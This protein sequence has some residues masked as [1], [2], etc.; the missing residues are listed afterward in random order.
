VARFS[1]P[2]MLTLLKI[3]V[4]LARY[5]YIY[6]GL[7]YLFPVDSGRWLICTCIVTE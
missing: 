7:P 5:L 3:G 4:S 2:L 1:T 6:E